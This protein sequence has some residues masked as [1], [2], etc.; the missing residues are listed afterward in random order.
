[1]NSV[2]NS[3]VQ[4][5]PAWAGFN[6][7]IS[8]DDP[9]DCPDKVLYLPYA[10]NLRMGGFH[11]EC[12]FVSVISKRFPDGAFNDLVIEVQLLEERSTISALSSP[13]YN[14]AMRIHKYM[15]EAFMQCKIQ[16]FEE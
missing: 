9:N 12:I 15:Y 10:I 6:Y 8:P 13:H 16:S 3:T 2:E 4:T 7:L 11:A 1:M 5:V 14:K